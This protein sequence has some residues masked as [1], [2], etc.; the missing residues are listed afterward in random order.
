MTE[1]PALSNSKV[2]IHSDRKLVNFRGKR[3]IF[4]EDVPGMPSNVGRGFSLGAGA[5]SMI[6]RRTK[7]AVASR[8]TA[9]EL[10]ALPNSPG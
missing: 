4:Y 1:G 5:I 3:K 8:A 10:S 2:K 9:L 6:R 7:A